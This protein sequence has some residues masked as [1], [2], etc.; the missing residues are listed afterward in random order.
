MNEEKKD[1]RFIAVDY[2]DP[3]VKD[4]MSEPSN[5]FVEIDKQKF[6][7]CNDG[8]ETSF[9]TM[10]NYVS[11]TG[12]LLDP[13]QVITNGTHQFIYA[14]LVVDTGYFNTSNKYQKHEEC[15]PLRFDMSMSRILLLKS[16]DTLQ[17][18]G[19][20]I[21]FVGEDDTDDTKAMSY[22]YIQVQNCGLMF[23]IATKYTNQI[24]LTGKLQKDPQVIINHSQNDYKFVSVNLVIPDGY[25]DKNGKYVE[26]KEVIPL[27]FFSKQDEIMTAKQG[28][29]VQVTGF[30]KSWGNR[31]PKKDSMHAAAYFYVLVKGFGIMYGSSIR[32]IVKHKFYPR[33]NKKQ[34]GNSNQLAKM[35]ENVS[36]EKQAYILSLLQG[37]NSQQ[38][39]QSFDESAQVEN[40]TQS[41]NEQNQNIDLS[42]IN[43]FDGEPVKTKDDDAQ[44][45][46][47]PDI[48]NK[49]IYE[50]MNEL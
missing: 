47:L 4:L 48:S 38:E 6:A 23:S 40:K 20:I 33:N 43:S 13:A 44:D 7:R 34:E 49:E 42:D 37:N 1:I 22:Y 50:A 15:V 26:H 28:D 46:V 14:Q 39:Q 35:I 2:D 30:V 18:T 21:R 5:N 12:H 8:L 41:K 19:R 10:N 17:I 32:K 45:N 27:R 9:R 29:T 36:P 31:D 11:M 25:K 24:F 3:K 16:S